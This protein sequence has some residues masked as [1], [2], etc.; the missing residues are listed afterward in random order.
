MKLLDIPGIYIV[1]TPRIFEIFSGSSDLSMSSVKRKQPPASLLQ[2]RVKARYEPEPESD[3]EDDVSEG[4][5]EEGAGSGDED[6]ELS[7]ESGSGS[8]E[9]GFHCTCSNWH[10]Y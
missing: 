5:S 6:E 1:A 8:D 2:R 3:F 9:V 10:I 7:G 4:P